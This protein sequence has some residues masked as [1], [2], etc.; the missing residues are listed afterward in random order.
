MRFFQTPLRTAV[1]ASI[2]STAHITIVSADSSASAQPSN[3]CAWLPSWLKPHWCT[4]ADDPFD[5][6]ELRKGL[7]EREKRE[8]RLR[9]Y[10][11]HAHAQLQQLYTEFE[12]QKHQ[13]GAGEAFRK[14]LA[15]AERNVA[16]ET[17]RIMY[18]VDSADERNRFLGALPAR[19]RRA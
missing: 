17:A 12:Q 5:W 8:Q 10:M 18:G 4:L 2:T 6:P 1:L 13:P 9:K 19:G 14:K 15:T 11:S 7:R 3:A 16:N